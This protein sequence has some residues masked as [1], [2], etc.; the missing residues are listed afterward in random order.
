MVGYKYVI[1]QGGKSRLGLL[2]FQKNKSDS[3]VRII[4]KL[5]NNFETIAQVIPKTENN[6]KNK[7][8]YNWAL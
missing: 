2:G 1:Y 3:I 4:P 8:N 7:H 6:S 5:D